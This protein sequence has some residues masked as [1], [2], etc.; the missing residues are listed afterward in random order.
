MTMPPLH[1]APAGAPSLDILDSEDRD[2]VLV[3]DIGIDGSIEAYIVEP[4]IV[5]ARTASPGLVFAHWFDTHAPNGNRT[6]FLDEAV[7]WVRARGGSA[8]LPQLTFPWSGDPTGSTADRERIA[9]DVARLRRC[10]DLVAGRPGVDPGRIGVVG[11]DFGG[12]HAI[13]LGTV[14]RRPAAYALIAAVPRWGDWFL[15]FWPIEEDRID[16]LRAMR[17]LDPIEHIGEVAPARVLLQFGRR[18]FFIAPMT[19][20]ELKAAAPEGTELKS[21]DAE[22]DMAGDEI[23]ADRTAF[24]E[25]A[26]A[27]G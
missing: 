13:I 21:Y 27:G 20:L 19:G 10:V 25:A 3:R 5:D 8:V 15:P 4:T 23:R 11:H 16:Y 26:L 12:M 22:H 17:P 24:L 18:D 14:D 6:E 1:E 7:D 9:G 2:G